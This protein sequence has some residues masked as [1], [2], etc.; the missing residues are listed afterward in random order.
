[1]VGYGFPSKRVSDIK[2][3]LSLWK[4]LIKVILLHII[5][6]NLKVKLFNVSALTG[7]TKET[8]GE[9]MAETIEKR[10]DTSALWMGWIGI[11]AGIISFFILP[12]ILG[13]V[14][15]IL[16]IITVNSKAKALGWWSIGIGVAGIM[17]HWYVTGTLF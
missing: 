12:F 9:K 4:K 17:I 16:G 5:F 15:I 1:M 14:A 6:V 7:K 8:G 3:A 11:A 2:E 10:N 13:A